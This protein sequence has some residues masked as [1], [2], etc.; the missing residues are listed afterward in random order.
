MAETTANASGPTH[1]TDLGPTTRQPDTSY[2]TTITCSCG[3]SLDIRSWSI[4]TSREKAT[5]KARR[6]RQ[7]E[8]VTEAASRRWTGGTYIAAGL[9]LA[10]CAGVAAALWIHQQNSNFND[11]IF[12]GN[13]D[14]CVAP[15]HSGPYAL[16]WIGGSI[17]GILILVGIISVGVASGMTKSDK[18]AVGIPQQLVPPSPSTGVAEQL[19]K[20]VDL[21]NAGALSDDEFSA[22]KAR[23]LS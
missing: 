11:C 9:V 20:L 4:G 18:A 12:G 8:V 3:W 13:I 15:S 7:G 16:M 2:L 6:H 19:Q 14:A 23:L 1:E 22:A 5:D 21:H 17:S 10:V